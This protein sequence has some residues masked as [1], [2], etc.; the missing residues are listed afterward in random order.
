MPLQVEHLATG[1]SHIK[2]LSVC[3]LNIENDNAAR[4]FAK[5]VLGLK[6]VPSVVLF[7]KHSRTY[8]KFKGKV[9]S[10]EHLLRFLNMVCNQNDDKTWTLSNA[11]TGVQSVGAGQGGSITGL[12]Q[13]RGDIAL[14]LV[15][16]A[17]VLLGVAGFAVRQRAVELQQQSDVT[18]AAWDKQDGVYRDLARSIDASI[19]RMAILLLKLVGARIGLG[20]EHMRT[21]VPKYQLLLSGPQQRAATTAAIDVPSSPSSPSDPQ[22][23]S[24][25]APLDAQPSTPQ[26]ARSK[27]MPSLQPSTPSLG[28][29]N[30]P[31]SGSAADVSP[32]HL[33][34]SAPTSSLT[35]TSGDRL[36]EAG[37]EAPQEE[38]VHSSSKALVAAAAASRAAVAARSKTAASQQQ[39]GG[40]EALVGA[41]QGQ[42]QGQD[43]EVSNSGEAVKSAHTLSADEVLRLLEEEGRD[44]GKVIERLSSQSQSQDKL[45]KVEKR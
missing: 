4:Y 20:V 9:H 12:V 30:R 39:G 43:N 15:G 34:R 28:S 26:A 27:S 37:A 8:Y 25:G 45:S 41:M 5:E 42:P 21:S 24:A 16:G 29:R 44:V 31:A 13:H 40:A 18:V 1:L 22:A 17:A 11:A 2:S 23:G 7:P 3:A 10:S 14:G 32:W 6:F 33:P 35:Q 36:V 19:T 38:D